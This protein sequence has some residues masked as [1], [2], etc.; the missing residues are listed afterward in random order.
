MHMKKLYE[1]KLEEKIG[2]LF[3]VGINGKEID[4]NIR[5]LITKYKVGGV[6]LYRKNYSNYD[7][8]L[9]LINQLKKINS[10]NSIPL[11]IAVDQEGGRVN[12]MPKEFKNLN[13]AKKL[14]LN[15]DLNVVKNSGRVLGKMLFKTGINMNFAPVMDI[16]KFP[17]NHP[18]GDRCYGDNAEKVCKYSLEVM[19][20]IQK[21][22]VISVVKHFP[23][24][25]A[26]K[27]DSHF[28]LPV[29]GKTIEEMENTDLIPFENAIKNGADSI[30]IGHLLFKKIDRIFP[31]SLSSKFITKYLR[32]KYRYNGVLISDDIKM[33]SVNFFYG[34][35]YASIKA[36]KAGNDIVMMRISYRNQIEI[37]N[38]LKNMIE[39][40]SYPEYKI[41]KKVNRILKLKEKYSINDSLALGCNIEE[42]NN[43]IDCIN[44]KYS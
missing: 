6:I 2:Q 22:N 40:K 41:N 26:T 13:S 39:N 7:E 43:E 1:L 3:M 21:Q 11:F 14:T 19:K 18:I 24:H 8:M 5:T 32:K 15:N 27:K 37:I 17:D 35:K 29:I 9:K 44:N 34:P 23:G 33:K 10:S 28:F 38:K 25:G 20:E 36:L 42:I 4:N 12:R 30:M 31:V 16:Q